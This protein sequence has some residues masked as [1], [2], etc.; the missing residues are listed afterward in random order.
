MKKILYLIASA[1]LLL[2]ACG[3]EKQEVRLLYW[4]I[5]NGMWHDQDNNYD[6]FVQFVKEQDPDI[7]VWCEAESRY[8]EYTATKKA[9]CAG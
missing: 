1:A 5:Q 8:R 9:G 6:N 3:K 7:C 2:T 4:N